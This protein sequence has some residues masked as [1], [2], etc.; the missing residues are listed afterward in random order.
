M[1]STIVGLPSHL[2][3]QQQ[4]RVRACVPFRSLSLSDWRA[5]PPLISQ[6]HVTA[7]EMECAG[8]SWL[9][10]GST[11]SSQRSETDFIPFHLSTIYS[12]FICELLFL[13]CHLRWSLLLVFL[14]NQSCSSPAVC[15]CCCIIF[16]DICF[17]RKRRGHNRFL[18]FQG[19]FKTNLFSGLCFIWPSSS[20]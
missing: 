19:H 6:R 14:L 3:G 13:F 20:V 15:R 9:P 12:V 2:G 7:A 16:Q 8:Q 10:Q 5:L 17:I 11:R 4:K 18:L 1:P